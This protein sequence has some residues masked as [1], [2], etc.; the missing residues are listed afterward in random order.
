MKVDYWQVIPVT[1]E[2]KSA[3]MRIALIASS[4]IR[5]K[6]TYLE[7]KATSGSVSIKKR[8]KQRVQ[9]TEPLKATGP[10]TSRYVHQIQPS[11]KNRIRGFYMKSKRG[12]AAP[13]ETRR[14]HSSVERNINGLIDLA[15]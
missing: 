14:Q 9:G 7:D 8:D 10:S 2:L 5:I 15:H 4:T 11:P 1:Q 6:A 13:L 12:I 3:M